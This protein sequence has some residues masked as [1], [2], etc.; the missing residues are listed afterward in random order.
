MVTFTNH[1]A[2]HWS[3]V[4]LF[5][6]LCGS[7]LAWSILTRSS[8]T[9]HANREDMDNPYQPT[10]S[11]QG[12]WRAVN[13]HQYTDACT[14]DEVIDILCS[15][16][17]L[18]RGFLDDLRG[19]LLRFQSM[20]HENDTTEFCVYRYT[21]PLEPSGRLRTK[22]GQIFSDKPLLLVSAG[23]RLSF[24]SIES[25]TLLLRYSEIDEA[26]VPA[27]ICGSIFFASGPFCTQYYRSQIIIFVPDEHR[28][29]PRV[30]V[31]DHLE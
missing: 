3:L 14:V 5:V 7:V 2:V 27:Y 20:Y 8:S 19:A 16:F 12:D 22:Y 23:E 15:E 21:V 10:R 24:G 17:E 28:E 9:L 31:A 18:D 13:C 29:L 4:L 25:E 11:W 6:V 30:F 26:G 1:L